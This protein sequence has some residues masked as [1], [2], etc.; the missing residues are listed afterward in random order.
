MKTPFIQGIVN[1][2]MVFDKVIYRFTPGR[3]YGYP[4]RK[5]VFWPRVEGWRWEVIEP[6]QLPEDLQG[7][8]WRFDRTIH[9]A[10]PVTVALKEFDRPA[11]W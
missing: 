8:L 3:L 11:G 6:G 4:W 5:L 7:S 2:T 9:H 10:G 1:A